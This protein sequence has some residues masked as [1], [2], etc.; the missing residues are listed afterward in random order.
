[1]NSN[2]VITILLSLLVVLGAYFV[3]YFG[4]EPSVTQVFYQTADE[5]S[6]TASKSPSKGSS[7]GKTSS[8]KDS[9]GKTSSE[10]EPSSSEEIS[11]E[12]ESIY[13]GES[14]HF[15]EESPLS[16]LPELSDEESSSESGGD[17]SESSEPPQENSDF[18]QV[19]AELERLYERYGISVQINTE[20]TPVL[21]DNPF[22]T[23][24]DQVMELLSELDTALHP[25]PS[26]L[27]YG[28]EEKG[29]PLELLL[30]KGDGLNV[31]S[32]IL[33]FEEVTQI[34]AGT[35]WGSWVLA[36]YQNL[37]RCCDAAL[38]ELGV[39]PEVYQQYESHHPVDFHYGS[40]YPELIRGE[41]T[42]TCFLTIASQQ[43]IE[44]DRAYLFA[45]YYDD[46]IPSEYQTENCPLWRKALELEAALF[47]YLCAK[48]IRAS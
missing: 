38:A 19:W 21:P 40:Y 37:S 27:F 1:M 41:K 45:V 4:G 11:S 17:S 13:D 34:V 14:S 25:L 35:D 7:G 15:S 44:A 33:N 43:S 12:E 32:G 16:S 46:A 26:R 8:S 29:Y 18:S 24:A 30:T 10:E 20:E 23:D 39:L 42:E 28:M 6:E 48:D 31:E 36:F 3:I 22:Y 5:Q 47:E 2:R 9:S